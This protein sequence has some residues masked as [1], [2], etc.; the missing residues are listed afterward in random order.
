MAFIVGFFLFLF[1]VAVACIMF[2]YT[3][4]T[5]KSHYIT[6]PYFAKWVF[7]SGVIGI[8]LLGLFSLLSR[9]WEPIVLEPK[10]YYGTYVIDRSFYPGRQ[11]DWQYNHFRFEMLSSDSA[12]FY[13]TEGTK[14][15]SVYRGK[16][17]WPAGYESA[18]MRLD[19]DTP[20]HFIMASN[21][22]TYRF[23]WN[24]RLV[25]ATERFGNVAFK[26]GTWETL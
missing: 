1:G 7:F 12:L 11:A 3:S 18:R 22:T 21:P 13:V 16:I 2:V 9:L 19:M 17:S 23:V 6:L 4:L 15:V 14:I 5:G 24:F 26:K 8:S 10:D 20:T 25:F